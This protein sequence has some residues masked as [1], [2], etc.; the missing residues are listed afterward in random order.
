MSDSLNLALKKTE[1]PKDKVPILKQLVNL[2][3]QQPEETYYL[4]EIIDIAK[5]NRQ[6]YGMMRTNQNIGL[7]YQVIDRDNDAMVYF[8]EGFAW[9][10]ESKCNATV[11]LQNLS[12]RIKSGLRS[13]LTDETE[14]RLKLYSELI[15]NYP[16]AKSLQTGSRP[17]SFHL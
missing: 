11:E 16:S 5:K 9:I 12:D 13:N 14:N 8:R 4:K 10:T 15:S 2:Y 17:W 6:P 3:W 1:N 7:I